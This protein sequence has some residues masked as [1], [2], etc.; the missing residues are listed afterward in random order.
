MANYF[1]TIKA[2]LVQVLQTSTKAKVVYNYEETKP[3]GYPAITVTPVSGQGEFI[4]TMRTRREFVFSIKC[5]QERLEAT[6][7]GAESTL[8]SL[9]DEILGIFDTG[10]SFTLG[11][12][13][14][15]FEPVEVSWGYV[16]APDADVRSCEIKLQGIVAQ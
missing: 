14:I 12:T 10:S 8:T 11:N 4:D 5:Y 7:S 15:F 13:V 16:Q 9:V 6:P 1:T 2:G 3:T